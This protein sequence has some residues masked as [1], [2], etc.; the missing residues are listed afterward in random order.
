MPH[1]FGFELDWQGV[2]CRTE[3]GESLKVGMDGDEKMVQW[4][5]WA[6]VWQGNKSMARAHLF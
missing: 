4:M 3:T 6:G 2:G 1:E 5:E